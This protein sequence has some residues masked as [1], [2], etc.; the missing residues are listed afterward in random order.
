VVQTDCYSMGRPMSTTIFFPGVRG[1]GREFNH[2]LPANAEVKYEWSYTS[3]PHMP[4]LRVQGQMHIFT[5]AIF[6]YLKV[7]GV[8]PS[9]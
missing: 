2:T 9:N 7:N 4:E 6:P 5:L 1:R 8:C 3:T